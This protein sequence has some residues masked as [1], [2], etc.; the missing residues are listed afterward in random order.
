MESTAARIAQTPETDESGTWQRHAAART[1]R[2][3][4]DGRVGTGRWGTSPGFPVL[5]LGRPVAS[6]VIAAY[7]HLFDPVEVDDEAARMSL[8]DNLVPRVLITCDVSVTRLLDLRTAG[9]RAQANLTIQDLLSPTNDRDAYKRCQQ[10]A[11]IAHQLGRHGI[12]TPAATRQ[13]ETLPCSPICS[14]KRSARVEAPPTRRGTV[15]PWT[16]GSRERR[17]CA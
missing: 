15:C 8:I 3:A 17:D 10:V 11:A 16:R 9:A 14:R 1:A 7:R 13:G 5:Y 4:L 6:V 2:H 12:I